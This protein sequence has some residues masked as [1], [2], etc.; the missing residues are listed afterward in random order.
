MDPRDIV[1]QLQRISYG[2]DFATRSGELADR[3]S[4]APDGFDAVEPILC[5]MDSHSSLD[6][7]M[8]GPLVHF[9][10]TFYGHGYERRLLD[11]VRRRPTVHTLWMLNRVINGTASREERQEFISAMMEAS[12]NPIAEVETRQRAHHFLNRLPTRERLS[13]GVLQS[14]CSMTKCA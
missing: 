2:D 5:F 4:D 7:G 3:W 11:S 6:Y 9:L 12:T 1:D 13:E 10:E 8:P 14:D